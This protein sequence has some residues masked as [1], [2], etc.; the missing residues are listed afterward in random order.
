MVQQLEH[1]WLIIFLF[2]LLIPQ[3]VAVS[4]TLTGGYARGK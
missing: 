2:V 1:W 3:L 4:A